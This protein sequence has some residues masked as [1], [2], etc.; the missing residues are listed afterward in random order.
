MPAPSGT[1]LNQGTVQATGEYAP[2]GGGVIRKTLA[3]SA[4]VPSAT[5]VVVGT[6]P[7]NAILLPGAALTTTVAFNGTTPTIN[8]GYAADAGG[9][10]VANAYASAQ[11]PPA[12][13]VTTA[14]NAV[15]TATAAPRAP[16]TTITANITYTTTTTGSAELVI[17]YVVG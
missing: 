7:S 14:L 5:N 4:A 3:F 15:G 10:A 16:V 8:V 12:I 13:G 17:P 2:A 9:A 11:A 1:S 6:L